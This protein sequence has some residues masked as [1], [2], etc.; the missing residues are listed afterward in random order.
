[1]AGFL[2]WKKKRGAEAEQAPDEAP[3]EVAV[4]APATPEPAVEAP[5]AAPEP[6]IE[7]APT[8]EPELIA[9]PEPEPEPIVEPTPVAEELVA[10]ELPKRSAKKGIRSLFS[11]VKF[12]PENLDELEDILIQADFGIDASMAIVDAVKLQA[13]KSGATTEV[14][15]KEILASV[16]ADNLEREDK[17]LN[18]SDG[19]LPYVF[20]VVGVNGVGKTT[21]IGKLANW[22]SEGE[23]K[24]FIGAADTFRAAAVEQV[25]TWAD[26]A[27]ASLI[28]PK[29]EGQDPASVAFESVEAAIKA[30]ADIVI[31]DTAGRLQNKT[32]LMGELDKIRRVIEK[33][34]KISEVLLVLDA[35]TGQNGMAQA[36]AF[37]EIANVTGVV[38]TKLDGTAK[39]G[40]VYSIQRELGI[41]VKLVGVGEGIND[42]AFFDATEFARGLVS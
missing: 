19:K 18:L 36:K 33:Q 1:M 34:A 4:E 42:F 25:A 13:K 41:P 29:T 12:N 15:L 20:L 21:T 10:V 5:V 17:S 16:I 3:V 2:F 22:L 37:A 39:G 6:A 26:R 11:R 9:E 28:R 14:E 38:L 35:T 40:I 7:S 30:D 24:V 31:I 32:D 23:W 8:V 27:G